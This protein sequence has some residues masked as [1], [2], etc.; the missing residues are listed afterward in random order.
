MPSY[1]MCKVKVSLFK[2]YVT[3]NNNKNITKQYNFDI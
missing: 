1:N 2:M 3:Q